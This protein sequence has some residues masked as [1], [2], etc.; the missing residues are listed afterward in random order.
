MAGAMH[1][2]A[3][4][5]GILG[6]VLAWAAAAQ[7]GSI[8]RDM[9]AAHNAVRARVD[10]PPLVWSETLAAYARE[11]ANTLAASGRFEHR[12]RGRY[13]ENLFAVHNTRFLPVQ[14][15]NDWAGEARL[16][17]LRSNT[18]RGDC[19]HYTQIVWRRTREVGCAVARNGP[20]E[21]WVCNYSPRG[22][23]VGERPY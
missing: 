14:V 3:L 9:L 5:T 8:E 11:W 4:R 20:R 2:A 21:V 23:R 10:V 22:N 7:T 16:Y 19:G 18:C 15:V 12:R 6:A 1:L 17:N 13:G